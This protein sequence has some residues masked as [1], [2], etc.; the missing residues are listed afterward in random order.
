MAV[1]IL[2]G[3]LLAPGNK[4]MLLDPL[5]PDSR[6]RCRAEGPAIRVL[7]GATLGFERSIATSQDEE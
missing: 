5:D 7:S 2:H 6:Q 4:Q 1:R 3:F